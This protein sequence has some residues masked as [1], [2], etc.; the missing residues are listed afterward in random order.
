MKWNIDKALTA[1]ES[2]N[3]P[4]TSVQRVTVSGVELLEQHLG[5]E[6]RDE[7]RQRGY[8]HLWCLGLGRESHRKLFIYGYE[9]RTAYLR[10]RRVMRR[11]PKE[12]LEFFGLARPRKRKKAPSL[13]PKRRAQ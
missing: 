9:I 8:A 4:G 7:D 2:S 3:L 11:L 12:D 10:A 6:L 5:K 13:K 1:L